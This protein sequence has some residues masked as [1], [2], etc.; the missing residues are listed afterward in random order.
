MGDLRKAF[1]E[2]CSNDDR[3]SVVAMSKQFA[4]TSISD[5]QSGLTPQTASE[6]LP[7]LLF[8]KEQSWSVGNSFHIGL[9]EVALD[10]S[11]ISL[12]LRFNE[13]AAQLGILG[14]TGTWL[15]YGQLGH[16]GRGTLATARGAGV[17]LVTALA[18]KQGTYDIMSVT[19]HGFTP[20][21]S[22]ALA[23][24]TTML[25]GSIL[26]ASKIGPRWLAPT[27]M[28]SGVAGR[29]LLHCNFKL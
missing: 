28:L 4:T 7:V 21:L 12:R 13:S 14:V 29:A 1:D 15:A 8:D 23:A 27:L 5:M 9:K 6:H 19:K 11:E 22:C 18:L 24:D 26:A 20:Q 17:G 3:S 16:P 10:E 25:T 2:K